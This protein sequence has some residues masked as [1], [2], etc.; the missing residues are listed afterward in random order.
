MNPAAMDPG[1]VG[2]VN[3]GSRQRAGSEQ[4]PGATLRAAG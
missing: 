4:R 3:H 1:N 2:P